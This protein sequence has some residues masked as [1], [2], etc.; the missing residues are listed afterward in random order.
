M[1]FKCGLFIAVV[2]C[3][4]VLACAGDE[5]ASDT[6][7]TTDTNEEITD[8]VISDVESLDDDE[9]LNA[10]YYTCAGETTQCTTEKASGGPMSSELDCE[11]TAG[12]MCPTS[13][14]VEDSTFYEGCG[15]DAEDTCAADQNVDLCSTMEAFCDADA[16]YGLVTCTDGVPSDPV[17]C[18]DDLACYHT[19][20]ATAA[21]VTPNSCS[22]TCFVKDTDSV[23]YKTTTCRTTTD[24]DVLLVNS[25]AECDT[26]AETF[27]GN[28]LEDFSGW[29]L[30]SIQ[31]E[32]IEGVGCASTSQSTERL[33]VC[34]P[35]ELQ[36]MNE[37]VQECDED[38]TWT[39]AKECPNGGNC[40]VS[41]GETICK[42]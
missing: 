42:E 11:I 22:I 20:D 10:C 33:N 4:S 34:E 38:G 13:F 19:G 31:G 6:T 29:T 16:D 28:S 12:L 2:L 9:T 35:G 1:K 41:N 17:A 15:C 23:D 26:L 25:Q 36:C 18:E 21:C 5:E 14:D 24:G 27:C 37:L 39:A 40:V 3:G 7:A 32:W 30:E 8:T